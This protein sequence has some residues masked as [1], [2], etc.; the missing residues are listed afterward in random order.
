MFLSRNGK[1]KVSSIINRVK[2]LDYSLMLIVNEEGIEKI[3]DID[4]DFNEVAYN[5]RPLFNEICDGEDKE[6]FIDYVYY[7]K[8][9]ILK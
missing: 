6:E 2:W 5:A 3:V 1:V 7:Y 9:K 8:R 4:K